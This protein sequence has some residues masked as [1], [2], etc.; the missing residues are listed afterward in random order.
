M[1]CSV[2]FLPKL[3]IHLPLGH[4][5]Q[6]KRGF[7]ECRLLENLS[8]MVVE[9]NEQALPNCS[10]TMD[11]NLL[12]VLTRCEDLPYQFSLYQT[13]RRDDR[14]VVYA[15]LQELVIQST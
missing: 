8:K 15:Q 11:Q 6:E 3:K 4:H 2:T 14:I 1:L 7:R 13:K 9:T 5:F 12:Q 10:E